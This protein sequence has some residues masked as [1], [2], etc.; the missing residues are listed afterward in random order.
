MEPRRAAPPQLSV[1][2]ADSESPATGG[3]GRPARELLLGARAAESP[4]S[5]GHY[6]HLRDP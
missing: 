1:R 3:A 4:H 5:R 6:D 2:Q